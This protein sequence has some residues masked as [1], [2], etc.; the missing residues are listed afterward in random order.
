MNSAH[1]IPFTYS[2]SQLTS[3]ATSFINTNANGN[4]NDC[5][6]LFLQHASHY[7]RPR[8]TPDEE[9]LW[10]SFLISET[11]RNVSGSSSRIEAFLN[12]VQFVHRHNTREGPNNIHTV[13]L[14]RFSDLNQYELPLPASSSLIV[15]WEMKEGVCLHWQSGVVQTNL[16]KS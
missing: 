14:N 13:G 9:G 16:C 10:N 4:R 8:L 2:E 1:A 15:I 6:D 11:P 5:R 7:N 3:C 12:S